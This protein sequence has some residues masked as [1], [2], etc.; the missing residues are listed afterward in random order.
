MSLM[1]AAGVEAS[2]ISEAEKFSVAP[3]VPVIFPLEQ[4]YVVPLRAQA[5]VPA[6]V[7]SDA[8]E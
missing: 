5:N 4:L 1:L 8:V 2:A 6:V 7:E 3:T